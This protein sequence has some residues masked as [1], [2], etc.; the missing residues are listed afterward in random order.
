MLRLSYPRS[1]SSRLLRIVVPICV[2]QSDASEQ[3]IFDAEQSL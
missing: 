1:I 2:V 3:A